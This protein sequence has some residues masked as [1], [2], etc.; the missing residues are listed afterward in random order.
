[1]DTMLFQS[2]EDREQSALVYGEKKTQRLN[3]I[4]CQTFE[5][6]IYAITS[7]RFDGNRKEVLVN[8]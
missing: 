3:N 7:L 8:N 4:D 5:P 1:M 6:S 2:V